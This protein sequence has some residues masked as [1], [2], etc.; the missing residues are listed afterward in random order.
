MALIQVY[1]KGTPKTFNSAGGNVI[2]SI[3]G[4]VNLENN[5]GRISAQTDL[6]AFPRG[7]FFEWKAKFRSNVAATVGQAVT[8]YAVWGDGAGYVDGALGTVDAAVAG[9]DKLLNLKQIG[10][11]LVDISNTTDYMTASGLFTCSSQYMSLLVRNTTGQAIYY[12]EFIM[13]EL[14]SQ[15]VAS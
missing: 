5:A 10:V 1:A 12:F 11:I 3:S 9:A 6:G 7:T 14:I 2:I 8:L 15:T 4:A 13:S